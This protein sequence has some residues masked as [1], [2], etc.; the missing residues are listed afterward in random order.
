MATR[1]VFLLTLVTCLLLFHLFENEIFNKMVNAQ[2]RSIKFQH[3]IHIYLNQMG[4]FRFNYV[5]IPFRTD[6]ESSMLTDFEIC[7]TLSKTTIFRCFE[8]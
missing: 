8:R 6:C 2:R 4:A 3:G 7:V 5:L 1:R